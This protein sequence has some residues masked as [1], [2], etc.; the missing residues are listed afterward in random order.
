MSGKAVAT[1]EAPLTFGE[2]YE[3]VTGSP[4]MAAYVIRVGED[5]TFRFEDAN[6][7]LEKIAGKPLSEIRGA[8]VQDCLPPDIAECLA[9]NL[10]RCVETGL[11]VN[12]H[13]T[14]DAPDGSRLS[15]KTSLSPVVR[16]SGP[17]K[18][19]IGFTRDVTH[20]T[21]LIENAQHNAAML[22]TLGM[23]LPS[24]IYLLDLE[25]NSISFIGG[26]VDELRHNWRKKAEEAGGDAVERY[27]HPDDQMRA[28]KHWSELAQ[29][30]DGEVSMISYRILAS[31]GEY[32]RFENRE[33][34]FSRNL[35]GKVKLV[36]GISEDVTEHDRIEQEVRDLSTRMLTLQIEERRRIAE[37]LHDSTGQHLTAAV[38]ALHNAKCLPATAIQCSKTYTGLM[39]IIEDA[40]HSLGEAQREIRVLS[41]LLH[42]PL[43]RSHGL[44]EALENFA[45]GFGKRAGLKVDVSISPDAS[46]IDDDTA[47]HLFR[48]CQEALTNVYRHAQARKVR[49][50]LEVR[51]GTILLTVK[52]DGIGFDDSA[53][54]RILGVGLPGMR[55]RMARLGGS[56]VINGDPGGTTLVAR[57]P[58][59]RP[60]VHIHETLPVGR[61]SAMLRAT[62]TH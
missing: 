28:K 18:F 50:A 7:F 16:H 55:E 42:P 62:S 6:D 45:N 31:E 12:Y 48:V 34:V 53:S 27:F 21:L 59:G 35:D 15:F 54:D 22:R 49:V 2:F 4:D 23:A 36:L 33:T 29:L 47:V 46:M 52:D 8:E 38:L 44:A 25:T 14:V 11:P 57:I 32:R 41:Y 19:V 56:V 20:E 1:E 60:E 51:D 9:N 26:S 39:A 13:R 37:E 10:R 3:V 40:S 24:S 61:T 5:G 58:T 30:D 17:A 43:L